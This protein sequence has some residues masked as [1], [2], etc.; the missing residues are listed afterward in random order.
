[1]R[2][3]LSSEPFAFLLLLVFP[4]WLIVTLIILIFIWLIDI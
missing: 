2:H 3:F 1:M 4:S